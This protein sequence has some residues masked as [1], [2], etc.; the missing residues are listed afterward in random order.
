MRIY[1]LGAHQTTNLRLAVEGGAQHVGISFQSL[2]PR[3]PKRSDYLV[4]ERFEDHLKVYLASGGHSLKDKSAEAVE[5][6]VDQFEQFVAVNASRLDLVTEVDDPRV[7]VAHRGELRAL[8]GDAFVPVWLEERGVRDLEE[9]AAEYP[10]VGIRAQTMRNSP[11]LLARLNPLHARYGTRW[12]LL[13]GA[14]PDE[15]MSGRFH[16]AATMAWL[17]PMKNAETI[18]F[19][20]V[21]MQRYPARMKDQ[22]RRRHRAQFTQA[23]FDA[24]AILEGDYRELTRYTVSAFVQLET[25]L[26]RRKPPTNPFR[27]VGEDEV[28]TSE[29]VEDEAQNVERVEQPTPDV[30]NSAV[31]VRNEQRA[32]LARAEGR[33]VLPILSFDTKEETEIGPDGEQITVQRLLAKKGSQPL[34]NCDTCHVAAT[35]PAFQPGHECAYS[36]PIEIRT[37]EQLS[38]ALAAFLEKQMDRVAFMLMQE[39]LN[40]G[41]ADPNT[42]IEVDRMM[43]M[44][45]DIR[46]V[47]DNRDFIKF[48]VEGKASAGVMSALFGEQARQLQNLDRPLPSRAID[49]ILDAEVVD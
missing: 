41:Y 20:G 5:N 21:R 16:S 32:P 6:F 43:K 17:S 19:D 8:L 18:V 7:P 49:N 4:S 33:K 1:L 14:R 27:V 2:L 34:R 38:A 9:L 46:E 24:D 40:G 39:E 36:L 28:S 30:D 25:Y 22:A 15:L 35:C 3:L 26:D 23:G 42:G 47:E 44:I 31:V 45:K 29:P 12:H 11:M 10:T 13:D 37:K 48:Q